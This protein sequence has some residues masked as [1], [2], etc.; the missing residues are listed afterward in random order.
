MARPVKAGGRRERKALETRGR[1]L[2]AA[3][4]LFV[5]RGYAATTIAAIAEEGDVA[6]QTVYAIFTNKRAILVDLLGVRTVGV[7]DDGP[8]LSGREQWQ[9]IEREPDP[10]RQVTRLADFATDVGQRLGELYV[11]LAGAAAADPEIAVLFGAQQEGRYADQRRVVA[12]LAGKGALRA[13]LS[14]ERATDMT[15][16]IAN[17]HMFRTLVRERGWHESEYRSWLAELL[18]RLLLEP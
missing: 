11:V 5:A 4:R 2:D 16:A 10:V 18:S 1:V 15:W 8:P 7:D 12:S 14:V 6:V 17:P 3:E 9:A 13:G